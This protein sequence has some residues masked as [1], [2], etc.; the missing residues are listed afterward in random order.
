MR[1]SAP[2]TAFRRS[3]SMRMGAFHRYRISITSRN[4]GTNGDNDR[5]SHQGVLPTLMFGLPTALR[6]APVICVPSASQWP[7]IWNT[8]KASSIPGFSSRRTM[9]SATSG[10]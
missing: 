9:V 7:S 3:F 1:G 10:R 5:I 6:I 8:A 4:N 2:S